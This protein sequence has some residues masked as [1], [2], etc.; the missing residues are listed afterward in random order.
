MEYVICL[1]ANAIVWFKLT[2]S[3][4][5]NLLSEVDFGCLSEDEWSFYNVK[6]F[7]KNWIRLLDGFAWEKLMWV[8]LFVCILLREVVPIWKHILHPL[9]NLQLNLQT[10]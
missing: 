6:L 8:F 10:F 3:I 7:E 1:K 9:P 2:T 5:V 4:W